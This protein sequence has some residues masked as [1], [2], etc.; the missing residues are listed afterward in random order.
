MGAGVKGSELWALLVPSGHIYF[1][2]KE[3]TLQIHFLQLLFPATFWRLVSPSPLSEET[4]VITDHTKGRLLEL[5]LIKLLSEEHSTIV[6]FSSKLDW[7]VA[8]NGIKNASS[9]TGA[10]S[11]CNSKS[12]TPLLFVRNSS[13]TGIFALLNTDIRHNNRQTAPLLCTRP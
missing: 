2:V 8:D 9:L 13:S 1:R 4:Q 12:Q 3:K 11:P 6:L 7:R 10:H 5:W